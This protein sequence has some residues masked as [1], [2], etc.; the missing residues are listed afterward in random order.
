[1]KENFFSAKR[2]AGMGILLAL[3]IVLQWF[4]GTIVIGPVQLNFTLVPIVLG[5]MVFG[6]WVGAFLGFSSG[7]IVLIQVI[8]GLVPFYTLIWTNDP[9][10]TSIVCLSKTTVAGL[11]AGF[12][13]N[14]LKNKNQIAAS[15][16]S[17]GIVPIINTLIFV[18]GCMCMSSVRSMASGDGS[19]LLVYI[20]VSIVT[21]NFFFEFAISLFL[22][23]A[24][25]RVLKAVKYVD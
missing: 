11:I 24:L 20:L 2:I 14:L 9:I 4:G 3:V 5:A 17:S 18:I 8:Q 13:Y 6:P 10:V 1:M 16:I 19:M 15:F 21:F 7:V 25:N 12:I 23:P 22:A